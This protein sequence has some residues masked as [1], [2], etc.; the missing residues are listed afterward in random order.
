[1][2]LGNIEYIE[3]S[4]TARK[5]LFY[6]FLVQEQD[7]GRIKYNELPSYDPFS[8]NLNTETKR[9]ARS[10]E[11]CFGRSVKGVVDKIFDLEE[12]F[13]PH[14]QFQGKGSDYSEKY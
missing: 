6:L 8:C 4:N 5:S 3:S 7:S 9:E 12:I 10:A 2:D 11:P 13:H 1:M 14:F